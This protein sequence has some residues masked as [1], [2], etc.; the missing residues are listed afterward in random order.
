MLIKKSNLK[1]QLLSEKSFKNEKEIQKFVS[2]NLLILFGLQHI[3]DEF[4]IRNSRI[5]TLAFDEET[6]AFVVIEY[7]NTKSFSVVDQGVAYLS[8]MLNNKADFILE[9]NENKGKQLTREDVDW[10]QSKVIFISPFFNN[11]QKEAINFKDLPI[12]L[13]QIKQYENDL[14]LLNQVNVSNPTESFNKIT[15][16]SKE[17]DTVKKEIKVYTEED[18]LKDKSEDIV[19][20]YEKIKDYVLSLDE[21]IKVKATKVYISFTINKKIIIDITPLKSKLKIWLNAPAGSIKDE[22]NIFRDVSN[23][24]HWGNGDYEVSMSN[25]ESFEYVMQYIKDLYNELK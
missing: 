14:I 6:Q 4:S 15:S 2:N 3:K 25:D 24:G 23:T 22:R 12:E 7:K 11:Y 8:N 20:L 9:Y 17:F 18:H 5:D 16:T 13:W 10:S 1:S 21:N 19:G